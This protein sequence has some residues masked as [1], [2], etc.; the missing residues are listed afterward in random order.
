MSKSKQRSFLNDWAEVG[1]PDSG[2]VRE[3]TSGREG[4]RRIVALDPLYDA[5]NEQFIYNYRRESKLPFVSAYGSEL[6]KLEK[7]PKTKGAKSEPADPYSHLAVITERIPHRLVDAP[8]LSYPESLYVLDR[9]LEGYEAAYEKAGP[10]RVNDRMIGF[11]NQ[12][13]CKVWVNEDFANNHASYPRRRLMSTRVDSKEF[14]EGRYPH[15]PVGSDESDMV[16][17]VVDTV[18][19]YCEEGRFP[20]PFASQIHSNGLGFTEARQLLNQNIVQNR[21]PVPNRV[22]LF[23]NMVRGYRKVTNTTSIIPGRQ[24][25]QVTQYTP[26]QTTVI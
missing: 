24:Q 6:L 13:E 8:Q 26:P 7:P 5:A 16:Q 11:N 2:I 20:E 25:Q 18:E 4:E 15:L 19:N 22:D 3:S 17:D 21:I 10:M 23:T 12:G 9:A 1:G 14:L